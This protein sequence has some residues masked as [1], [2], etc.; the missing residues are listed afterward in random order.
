[1]KV[2]RE[3]GREWI[4]LETPPLC[5]HNPVDVCSLHEGISFICAVAEV[6][7]QGGL[8]PTSASFFFG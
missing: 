5:P 8:G 2:S 6:Q 3:L 4:S 7:H 1:M